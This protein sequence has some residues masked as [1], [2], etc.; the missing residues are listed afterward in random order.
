MGGVHWTHQRL[1]IGGEGLEKPGFQ[2]ARPR[3]RRQGLQGGAWSRLGGTDRFW[4]PERL[5]E[6]HRARGY[7]DASSRDRLHA[8]LLLSAPDSR[9]VARMVSH[10]QLPA[11]AGPLAA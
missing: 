3:G 11:P 5:Y 2:G 9:H 10:D 4:H 1:A 7:A 6:F 8:V